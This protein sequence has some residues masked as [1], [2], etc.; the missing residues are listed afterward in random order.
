MFPLSYVLRSWRRAVELH[1]AII[2]PSRRRLLPEPLKEP[3]YQPPYTLVIELKDLLLK[4]EWTVRPFSCYFAYSST[5]FTI[6]TH[7]I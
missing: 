4:P 7:F 3:Y 6:L 2:E 5:D 1:H